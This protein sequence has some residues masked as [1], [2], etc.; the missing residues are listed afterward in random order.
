MLIF[1]D[2]LLDRSQTRLAEASHL[3]KLALD[4]LML[5]IL[6]PRLD[7]GKC[8]L[9]ILGFRPHFDGLLLCGL[10]ALLVELELWLFLIV[11][12]SYSI[13]GS[14]KRSQTVLEAK[15]GHIMQTG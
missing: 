5:C 10:K 12:L 9:L 7:R 3:R 11:M 2:T 1:L 15:H 14:S 13:I 6:K 4:A 8:W